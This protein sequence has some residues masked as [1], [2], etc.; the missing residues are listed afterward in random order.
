MRARALTHGPFGAQPVKVAVVVIELLVASFVARDVVTV[1]ADD[2]QVDPGARSGEAH[3]ERAAVVRRLLIEQHKLRDALQGVVEQ[4]LVHDLRLLAEDG[5]DA[6]RRQRRRWHRRQ[7]AVPVRGRVERPRP[8][9]GEHRNDTIRHLHRGH[10]SCYANCICRGVEVA[11]GRHIVKGRRIRARLRRLRNAA[12][13]VD[14]GAGV[15]GEER[16]RW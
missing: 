7:L 3:C 12:N 2:G 11:L 10:F 8:R 4:P 14:G 15:A 5:H 1:N 13:A 6:E 16:V 9:R